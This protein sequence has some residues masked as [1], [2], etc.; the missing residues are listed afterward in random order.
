[1]RRITYRIGGGLLAFALLTAAL[2]AQTPTP[3]P[4]AAAAAAAPP[5]APAPAQNSLLSDDLNSTLPKWVHINGEYRARFEGLSGLG[6]KPDAADA[7]LLGRL[8]LNLRVSPTSWMRFQVQGQDSQAMFRNA[9]PDAPPYENTFDLRQGYVE[10]GNADKPPITLR[11]GR[12]ELFFGEQRLIGHL[13]WT[14]TARSFDA[15]RLTLKYGNFKVD[16]FAS[17]VVN[18]KEGEYDRSSGGNDLH[19]AYASIEKLIPNATG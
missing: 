9:K 1:L 5:K 8:R 13:N 12:Q 19:G 6:F 18:L 14:N 3:A 7:F 10:L 16:A 11:V 15:A 4:A 17:S 2:S